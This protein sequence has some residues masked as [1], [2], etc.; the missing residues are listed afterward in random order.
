LV[1]YIFGG[2]VLFLKLTEFTNPLSGDK[3]NVFDF[4]K[5]WSMILGVGVLL[6]IFNVGQKMA[7][8]VAGRLPGGVKAGFDSPIVNQPQAVS[9]AR[10]YGCQ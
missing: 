6:I 9:S 4:G 1:K 3:G 2:G 5:L 10:L 8:T 7:S